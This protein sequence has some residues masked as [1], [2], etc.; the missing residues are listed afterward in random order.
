MYKPIQIAEILNRARTDKTIDLG[1]LDTYRRVS[2]RWRNDVCPRLVGKKPSLNSRYEDQLFDPAVLPPDKIVELGKI[3]Q[4]SDGL[5]EVYIYARLRQ[6]FASV[7]SIREMLAKVE[8]AQFKLTDFL[9]FFDEPDLRRS[10]DKA[11]EVIVYSLFDSIVRH[12]GATVTLAVDEGKMDTLADF[13]DFARV[14]LGIDTA[15]PK[16]VQPAR[17][18][19]VGTANAADAGLDMWANFGPAIQIKHVTLSL[20]QTTD[21]VEGLVADRVVIVCR[22]TEAEVIES[23]MTQIGMVDRVQGFITEDD[24]VKWYSLCMSKKYATTLGRDLLT[25]LRLQ[26]EAEF[27][28]SELTEIDTFFKERN[29]HISKLN[30]EWSLGGV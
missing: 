14:V 29:Y 30:G 4:Q 19:R 8:A 28:L 27:P 10:V 21:I 24:L 12:L 6:R 18:Y 9:A 23:I 1:R 26:F 25:E 17:L 13:E 20:E 22:Q 3:N 15:H 11:Y 16:L 5:V 7:A 2:T